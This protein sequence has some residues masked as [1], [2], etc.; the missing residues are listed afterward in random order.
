MTWDYLEER[1]RNVAPRR[2]LPT[3]GFWIG[4]LDHRKLA[5]NELEEA[6]FIWMIGHSVSVTRLPTRCFAA[7]GPALDSHRFS[8]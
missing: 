1:A 6:D 4:V 2:V 3:Q 7:L 5:R 8:R